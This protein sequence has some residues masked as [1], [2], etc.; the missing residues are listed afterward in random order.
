MKQSKKPQ[1]LLLAEMSRNLCEG[2]ARSA[3]Q[4]LGAL[5]RERFNPVP[6]FSLSGGD[7]KILESITGIKTYN[8]HMPRPSLTIQIGDMPKFMREAYAAAVAISGIIGREKI[9]VAHVNSIIN[10]HAV[11][12]CMRCGAPFVLSVR[13]MM[14]VRRL[15]DRYIR[16]VCGRAAAVAAVSNAVR[17][18]LLDAGVPPKKVHVVY[19]A[20]PIIETPPE[21]VAALRAELGIPAGAPVVGVVGTIVEIKGQFMAARAMPELLY[22][23]PELRL[24]IVGNTIADGYSL[25]YLEMIRVFVRENGLEGKVIL[26]GPRNDVP[27]FMSMFDALVQPSVFQDPLPRTVLEAMAAGTP[28]VGTRVGGIPEM[29]DHGVTGLLV[30]PVNPAQIVYAVADILG[31][32]ELKRSMGDAALEKVKT[33]FDET[34]QTAKIMN[35]YEGKAPGE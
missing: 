32:P 29:I 13:E 9:Q 23:F 3:I 2:P 33:Q 28:V 20:A 6:V 35:L 18:R 4:I 5:D 17:Q 14:L 19:N 15:N 8:A 1:N 7:Q 10:L 26:T 34:T 11:L 22:R 25:R 12:A 21:E 31:S 27:K 16:W 24:V 30:D